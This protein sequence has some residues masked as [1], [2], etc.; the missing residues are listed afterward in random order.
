MRTISKDEHAKGPFGQ[1]K[2]H[3]V[4]D[5]PGGMGNGSPWRRANVMCGLNVFGCISTDETKDVEVDCLNCLDEL[6]GLPAQ[7]SCGTM[8]N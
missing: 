6:I 1:G 2:R 3:I 5:V 4:V 7:L 8:R